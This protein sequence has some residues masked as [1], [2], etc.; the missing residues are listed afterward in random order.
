MYE[1]NA[2]IL[3]RYFDKMFGYDMKYNIKTNFTEYSELVKCLEE[4]KNISEEEETMAQE[5]D[6]IAN[7]IREIQKTQENLNKR[8]NK[9]QEERN[10]LF[11]NI[12]EN[13]SNIQK[14]LENLN[15]N[16]YNIDEEIKNN[17]S[18]FVEIIAEFNEKAKIR[19][20]CERTRRTVENEYNKKLNEIL[21]HYKEINLSCETKAKQFI[22]LDTKEIEEELK[23]KIQK[24]GEKEKIQFNI[25]VIT[26]AICLCVDIQKRETEILAG[27][28][29]KTNKLFTEIKNNT[30]RLDKHKKAIKDSNSKIE[31]IAAIKEYLFQFLDN[32]RLTAVN[33][34][35]EHAKLMQEACKH[36]DEDLGQINNLYTLLLKEISKKITKKSYTE[37]YKLDYLKELENKSDEFDKEVKK[38][39]L[40]VTI[41][42]PNYWRI[43]GMK[44]IYNVFYRC[45]TETYGRDLSEYITEETEDPKDI[46]EEKDEET[47]KTEISKIELNEEEDKQFNNKSNKKKKESAKEELDKKIDMILGFN[48]DILKEN[49]SSEDEEKWN[50]EDDDWD[51][52]E[53]DILDD[54]DEEDDEEENIDDWDDEENDTHDDDDW[55]YEENDIDDDWNED[56]NID[57]DWND[58][59][60]IND[61]WDDD[62]IDEEDSVYNEEQ[63][64]KSKDD[65]DWSNEFVKMDKKDK[66]KKKKGFF[67][68][69][70]K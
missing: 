37:L 12:D 70:K 63:D 40:P 22:D 7:K 56:E 64:S 28:Y 23:E 62:T 16:I 39:N 1:R 59:E 31:F 65:D 38:L 10:E 58:E 66:P 68:K 19:T 67:D 41:I 17:A 5:Y 47:I 54:L 27:I 3:E 35:V 32:E 51:D 57:D 42:N 36:L 50:E 55:G 60:E 24:N 8:N 11:Q 2:I 15:D 45:V 52:D 46:F 43:E 20:S 9:L 4:Y 21:D 26:K 30:V 25:D 48:N 49:N 34:E 13:E 44:R 61:D 53:F 29:E 69:F 6:A 18:D 14:K 33:G